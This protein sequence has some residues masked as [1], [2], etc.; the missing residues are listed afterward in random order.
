MKHVIIRDDDISF[1]TPVDVLETLYRPL[2]DREGK[3]SL[4]VIP[5]IACGRKVDSDNG[6]F[7][8]D[9]Q[10]E[11]SPFIPPESREIKNS[12]PVN[13]NK[14]LINYLKMG[15]GYEI[16]QHGY[17]HSKVS[18]LIEGYMSNREDIEKK[19]EASS[20]IMESA[21]GK[22]ADFF[23]GPWDAFS[24]ETISCLR[25]HFK[26]ISM[27]RMGKR[28]MPW[29]LKPSAVM[30]KL[31]PTGRK[32]G[33]FK[34][35]D[36][37]IFEHPGTKISMF[38]RPE[39]ILPEI[40]NALKQVDILVLVTHHWEFFFDWNELNK[41]FFNAWLNI[42]DFLMADNEICVTDFHEM[43]NK[44]SGQTHV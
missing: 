2:L 44:I 18:G 13:E 17:H 15:S 35:G 20:K 22:K 40:K 3:V 33:Y 16:L 14:E 39:S 12:Y 28:H 10:M 36:F 37:L 9:L 6:P 21:F 41:P 19:I 30:R 5:E 4:S 8:T 43:H 25:D 23:V 24:Y 29:Y 32:K 42:L 7:W 11:Y 27:Y 26:G 1:F 34:W 31:L 38:N